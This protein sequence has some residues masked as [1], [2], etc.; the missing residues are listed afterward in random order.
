MNYTQIKPHSQLNLKFLDI[1]HNYQNLINDY[2]QQVSEKFLAKQQKLNLAIKY[3]LLNNGKRVRAAL[4]Y[5][6][7]DLLGLD[8]A[9][10]HAAAASVE[11]IH[12]YS[13]VHDDLP[14]MD[15]DDLRRGQP[16]CHKV[17]DEATAILAG[18]AMQSLA[19]ELISDA[20]FNPFNG[21]I[22]SDMVLSLAKAIG[23]QGMVYG[24]AVDIA[25][26]GTAVDLQQLQEIHT[27]K[28]GLLISCCV[29]LGILAGNNKINNLSAN[30][31]LLNPEVLSKK[32]LS[33][34]KYL[35]LIFQIKDDILDVEQSSDILGKPAKSDNKADKATFVSILSLAAAKKQLAYNYDLAI[36]SLSFIENLLKNSS[37]NT[38]S[39]IQTL[40]QFAEFFKERSF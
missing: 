19:F 14:A 33:Y 32:L 12:C 36:E 6:V 37:K 11:L 7:A 34:A 16:S 40:K 29:Q 22:R 5:A 13:L 21:Q 28:T 4:V 30:Q 3:S 25:S 17:F 9:K 27:H 1:F 10:M 39:N 24:Q 18:D 23:C 15:D 38:S 8:L 35:G 2:L 20:N 26:E 31:K